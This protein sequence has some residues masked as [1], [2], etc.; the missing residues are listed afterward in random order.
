MKKLI[1]YF[2]LISSPFL[3]SAQSK[4]STAQVPDLILCLNY[5]DKVARPVITNR[6]AY[7]LK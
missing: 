3:A 2:I 6:A 5:L 1:F 7:Q 4:K